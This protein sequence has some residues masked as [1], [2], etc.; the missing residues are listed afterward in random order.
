MEGGRKPGRGSWGGGR[1][2]PP[3][4]SVTL[5]GMRS[6]TT[7]VLLALTLPACKEDNPVHG[8][9]AGESR[10]K[11]LVEELRTEGPESWETPFGKAGRALIAIGEDGVPQVVP[12]LGEEKQIAEKAASVLAEMGSRILPRLA[13]LMRQERER[14]CGHARCQCSRGE[15]RNRAWG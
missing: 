6:R 8:L 15:V 5:V 1:R 4:C 10:V 2:H 13:N 11:K 12:L 3:S 14:P 9:D 7:I